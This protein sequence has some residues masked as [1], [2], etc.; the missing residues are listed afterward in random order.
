MADAGQKFLSNNAL[1]PLESPAV[2]ALKREG[3]TSESRRATMERS[4]SEDI[5]EERE[6]LKEA[7]E[8]TQ[9]V[10][11]ELSIDGVIRWVSPSWQ[12]VV[13]TTVGE[14]LGKPI[15]SLLVSDTDAFE[16]AAKAIRKDDARSQN[17]RFTVLAG[18][19]STMR[20][21]SRRKDDTVKEE[22]NE[23][24]EQEQEINLD[25]EGQ[26]IMVYDRTTGKESHVS[27]SD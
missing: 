24:E 9:S 22:Q 15:S 17:I 13:G 6:D 3:T 11:V 1:L 27:S 19:G 14:V 5:R 8:Y 18:P 10:V 21:K 26:G 2:S 7:T 20:R 12:D 23:A 25:L 4:L 16:K